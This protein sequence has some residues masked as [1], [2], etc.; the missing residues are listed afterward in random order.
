MEFRRSVVAS[1]EWDNIIRLWDPASGTCLQVLHYPDDPGNYFSR[2][3]WS[4]DGQRL[5]SGTYRR[6]VQVFEMAPDRQRWAG[7]EFPTWIRHVDWSPDGTR[8]ASGSG[9]IEGG[10]LFVWDLHSGERLGSFA[11]HPGIVY[12]VAW[13]GTEIYWS[14]G[15]ATASCAGGMCKVGSACGC[16]NCIRGQRSRSGEARMGRSWRAAAMMVLSC[17]GISTLE[18]TSKHSVETAPT[19]D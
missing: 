13:V 3:V 5:A 1:S 19:S 15:A 10:E 18:S 14:A 12:A 8:L 9:G 6:G 11:G 17:S 16:A 2:L 7:R 4:P